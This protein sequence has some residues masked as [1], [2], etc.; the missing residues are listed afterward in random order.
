MLRNKETTKKLSEDTENNNVVA[1]ADS[2][3][4]AAL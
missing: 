3:N 2:N 1:T 4:V